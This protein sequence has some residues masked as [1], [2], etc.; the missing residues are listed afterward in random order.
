MFAGTSFTTTLPVSTITF[1]PIVILQRIVLFAPIETPFFTI[2]FPLVLFVLRK[3]KETDFKVLKNAFSYFFLIFF[4]T[5]LFFAKL[6]CF[7]AKLD[8]FLELSYLFLLTIKFSKT[9]TSTAPFLKLFIASSGV[10]T[11]G[12]SCALNEVFTNNGRPVISLYAFNVL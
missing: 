8:S 12:S 6:D 2:V 3:I 10:Q 11:I 4:K 1:S 7:F 5:G 9:K